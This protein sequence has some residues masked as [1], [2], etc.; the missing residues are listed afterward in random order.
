MASRAKS[1]SGVRTKLRWGALL[2]LAA[3][4]SAVVLGEGIVRVFDL[5]LNL[6]DGV[7][8]RLTHEL[9]VHQ[10]VRD[11]SLLLTLK[12][13]SSGSYRSHHGAFDVTINSLGFRGAERSAEKP[14]GVFRILCVGGSNV[15]GAGINDHETWPA[16]LEAR[17]NDESPGRFEVWNLGVSGYNAINMTATAVAAMEKYQPDLIIFALSNIGPRFFLDGTPDIHE[18]YLKD[19]TLWL[20]LFSPKLLSGGLVCSQ[21]AELFLLSN[22]RLYRYYMLSRLAWSEENHSFPADLPHYVDRTREFLRSA[23]RTVPIAV[24]LAPPV[25]PGGFERTLSGLD[26]PVMILD[27]KGKPEGYREWHPSTQ[28]MHWY[29]KNLARMLHTEGLLPRGHL[30]QRG[31]QPANTITGR[32]GTPSPG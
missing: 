8:P 27:A 23:S 30:P 14:H 6:L 19:E 9:E 10:H 18:Y 15:Y 1:P 21:E 2:S 26:V 16:K 20:D 25:N 4:L 12:P 32:A 24:F 17:L 29:A 28:V 13:K 11:P 22:I 3:I 5:D 31:S 7:V